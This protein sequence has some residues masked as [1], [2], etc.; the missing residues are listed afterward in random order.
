MAHVRAAAP[1]EQLACT[2]RDFLTGL[3]CC[4]QLAGRGGLAAHSLCL[5]GVDDAAQVAFAVYRLAGEAAPAPVH[6]E[7]RHLLESSIQRLYVDQRLGSAPLDERRAAFARLP[8]GDALAHLH[9]LALPAF[10]DATRRAFLAAA[11]RLYAALD[12][13][14]SEADVGQRLGMLQAGRY[15]GAATPQAIHAIAERAFSAFEIALVLILN[16]LGPRRAGEAF[17]GCFDLQPAWVFHRS[18]FLDQF[19]E[20][21]DYRPERRTAL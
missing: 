17:V 13:S 19:S 4:W 16:G 9:G 5:R 15:P 20:Y 10:R 2:V 6:R 11:H 18:R 1:Q 8:S 3:Q 14:A 7:L 21:Y 12:A